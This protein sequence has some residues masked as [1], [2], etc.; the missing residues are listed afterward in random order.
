MAKL[1]AD[2]ELPAGA[3]D[4]LLQQLAAEPRLGVVGTYLSEAGPDGTLR[5][6]RIAHDHVH[7]ATKFYRRACWEAISPTPPILG[8]DTI[9][10]VTA[11][12]HGWETRSIE[13]STGDPLHLRPRGEHDGT[14]RAYRRWGECAWGIGESPVHVVLWSLRQSR[15]RPRGIGALNYFIGWASAGLRRRPR[16]DPPVRARVRRE[17]LQRIA[18]R[19]RGG[20]RRSLEPRP[21]RTPGISDDGADERRL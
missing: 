15:E 5:R 11:R 4:E 14:L 17:Q 16:A 1:D 12:L 9:D 13:L 3:L 6:L 10:E 21:Q 7:G 2:L 18:A 19:L 20:S 8:W